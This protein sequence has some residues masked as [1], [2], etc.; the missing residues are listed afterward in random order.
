MRTTLEHFDDSGFTV[1]TPPEMEASRKTIRPLAI[2]RPA[3]IKDDA[4]VYVQFAQAYSWLVHLK[5]EDG[6][7]KVSTKV[8]ISIS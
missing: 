4:L 7:W 6:R 8:L 2:S 3:V 5:R 1:A